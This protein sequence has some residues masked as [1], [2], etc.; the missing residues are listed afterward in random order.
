MD[1]LGRR[2]EDALKP[3]LA[4][5]VIA[6]ATGAFLRLDALGAPSYWLDEILDAH[7]SRAALTHPWWHW[8]TGFG[9]EHGPLHFA[10]QLVAQFFSEGELA[11]RLPAALFGL[12]TIVLMWIAARAAGESHVT[13]AVAALLLATSPFH[14]YYSREARPYSLLMLL[15]TALLIAVL[16]ETRVAMVVIGAIAL[17]TS[18]IAAGIVAAAM[19]AGAALRR[20]RIAFASAGVLALFPL[21]YRSPAGAGQTAT[22]LSAN[23]LGLIARGFTVSASRAAATR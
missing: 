17:Y 11:G 13:A 3:G 4:L 19:I 8:I 7:F 16:R 10:I 21:L 5:L 12:A 20:W 15:A 22:Q 6:L 2:S 18:A 9:R 14:V 23:V 1:A